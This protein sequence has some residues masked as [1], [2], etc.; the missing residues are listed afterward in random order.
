MHCVLAPW[1]DTE[2]AFKTSNATVCFLKLLSLHFQKKLKKIKYGSV[3][4]TLFTE[5][6]CCCQLNN[7]KYSQILRMIHY[8]CSIKNKLRFS[9]TG[10]HVS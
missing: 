10:S 7:I 3:P 2:F 5:N 1:S 8:V 6:V 9:E 4:T